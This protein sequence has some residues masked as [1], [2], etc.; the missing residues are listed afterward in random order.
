MAAGRTWLLERALHHP[1]HWGGAVG[2]GRK[3]GERSLWKGSVWRALEAGLRHSSVHPPVCALL[4]V[5]V[6][7][8]TISC[9]WRTPR[10]GSPGQHPHSLG[11]EWG[12]GARKTKPL[13]SSALSTF[14]DSLLAVCSLNHGSVTVRDST[15]DETQTRPARTPSLVC[16]N[17]DHTGHGL[18]KAGRLPGGGDA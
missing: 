18:E 16:G 4:R 1:P 11:A 8:L 17:Q 13:Q 2:S 5:L 6:R 9:H 10:R 14:A 7:G 3:E 15:I 12:V